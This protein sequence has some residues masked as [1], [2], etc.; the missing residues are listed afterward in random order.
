MLLGTRQ[1]CATATS[2]PVKTDRID[3][4]VRTGWFKAV[5]VKSELSQELWALLPDSKLLVAKLRDLDNGIRGLLR[6]SELKV[7]QMTDATFP[8]RVRERVERRAGLETLMASLLQAQDAVQTERERLHR[9]VLVAMRHDKVCRR[10]MTVPGVEP[11]NALTFCSTV[12]DLPRFSRSR[13]VGARF[14]LTPKRYQSAATGRVEHIGKEKD[15]LARRALHEAAN[16]LLNRTSKWLALMALE[17]RIAERAGM[18]CAKMALA[19]NVAVVL[20]R[21]WRTAP[22][23]AGTGR[24]TLLTR[25]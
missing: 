13:A 25:M 22:S 4:R 8:A 3:A 21:I 2:T 7:G 5:D 16:V 10:L 12:D 24:C 23:S 15:S 18:C 6:G 20:H 17:M 11:V 1:L 14:G 19:R 9:L